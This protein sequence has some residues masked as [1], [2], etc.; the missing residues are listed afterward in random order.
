MAKLK[1]PEPF[2]IRHADVCRDGGSYSIGFETA[3]SVFYSIEL[4]VELDLDHDFER[5]GYK[6]PSIIFYQPQKGSI[7]LTW[8]QSKKISEKLKG[9]QFSEKVNESRFH[10]AITLLGLAGRLT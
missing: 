9:C 5:I 1:V 4:P 10:E 3:G 2:L 7:K 6:E 8:Q